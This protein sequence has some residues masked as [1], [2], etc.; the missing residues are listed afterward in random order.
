MRQRRRLD[1]CPSH[2]DF[3]FRKGKIGKPQNNAKG[4][5]NLFPSVGQTLIIRPY[6]SDMARRDLQLFRFEVWDDRKGMSFDKGAAYATNEIGN[7]LHRQNVYEVWMK[8]DCRFPRTV[9]IKWSM[10]EPEFMAR[11]C[12]RVAYGPL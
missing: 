3:G 4:A 1:G 10:N 11:R 12:A 6:K 5:A 8:D 7:N 2:V 9:G